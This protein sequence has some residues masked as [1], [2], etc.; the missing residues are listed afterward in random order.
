MTFPEF[1]GA[2]GLGGVVALLVTAPDSLGE[3]FGQVRD[4]WVGIGKWI[5]S[6][7]W[8]RR[9]WASGETHPDTGEI[10]PETVIPAENREAAKWLTL[11][12][13]GRVIVR[14]TT[15]NSWRIDRDAETELNERIEKDLGGGN[16]PLRP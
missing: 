4:Q 14:N 5:A 1:M 9:Q 15:T 12:S 7:V 13:G 16:D 10:L 3:F 2:F 11:E 8:R 6:K